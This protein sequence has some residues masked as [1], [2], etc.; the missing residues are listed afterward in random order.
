MALGALSGMAA[1]LDVLIRSSTDALL[2]L[3]YHRQFTHALAFVPFG[4]LVC[5]LALHLPVGRG[6]RLRETYLFCLLGF[7]THG[8]LDACTSYGT[9]LLWPFSA[10]RIAWNLIAVVDPMFTLPVLA[11]LFA[12][13]FRQAPRYAQFALLWALAYLSVGA[14]QHG[15]AEDTARA[16][17]QSRGHVLERLTVKPAFGNLLLWK[18]VYATDDAFYVDAVRLGRRATLFPGSRAPRLDVSRD[19]PWLLPGSPL[20]ADVARFRRFSDDWVSAIDRGDGVWVVD[21]RYSMVPNV[22]D[23]LWGIRLDP[24]AAETAHA[25]F[26]TNRRT[27]PAHRRALLE[28][29]RPPRD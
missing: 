13:A 23:A 22:I 6:L 8:L 19:L 2:F 21:I 7:A 5:A 15:R 27:T 17:A 14:L 25:A 29:L 4:A 26:V 20:A 11:L 18:T 28:M 24:D 10:E 16:L 3:E 12:A 9:A 1:D